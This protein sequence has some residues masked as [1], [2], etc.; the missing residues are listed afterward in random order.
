MRNCTDS[1][2]GGSCWALSL[3]DYMGT[4]RG[5]CGTPRGHCGDIQAVP[6]TALT[7]KEL[8]WLRAPEQHW[9]KL[10]YCHTDFCSSPGAQGPVQSLMATKASLEELRTPAQLQAAVFWAQVWM[11]P[12]LLPFTQPISSLSTALALQAKQELRPLSKGTEDIRA[13]PKAAWAPLP[14]HSWPS[15]TP[16]STPPARLCSPAPKEQQDTGAASCS[17]HSSRTWL[18]SWKAFPGTWT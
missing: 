2:S 8:S 6:A 5:H 12:A 1:E 7:H 10:S 15:G 4:A 11:A 3:C 16:L 9:Q 14:G 17:Q 13:L 18:L